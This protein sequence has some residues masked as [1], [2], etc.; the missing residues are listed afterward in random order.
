MPSNISNASSL[1]CSA[2]PT[3]TPGSLWNAALRIGGHPLV[4]AAILVSCATAAIWYTRGKD[5]TDI[6]IG[7]EPLIKRHTNEPAEY[8]H[9]DSPP[10]APTKQPVIHPLGMEFDAALK[11]AMNRK[12]STDTPEDNWLGM[13][14]LLMKTYAESAGAEQVLLIYSCRHA[15]SSLLELLWSGKQTGIDQATRFLTALKVSQDK[16]GQLEQASNETKSLL[17]EALTAH[18]FSAQ[19]AQK[20][21]ETHPVAPEEAGVPDML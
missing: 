13:N 14:A 8:A 20:I 2:L 15:S 11:Q 9:N 4:H 7:G 17:T 21:V 18:L 19:T 3:A 12:Y 5:T 1:L 16:I 6:Q 10:L